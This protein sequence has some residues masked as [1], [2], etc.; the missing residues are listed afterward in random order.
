MA[1]LKSSME[2]QRD[3]REVEPSSSLGKAFRY[4]LGHWQ[5]LTQFLRVPGAPLDN[6]T[7]ERALKLIIRQRKNSL[8]YATAH[9]AYVASLLTS[10]IATCTQAGVNAMAYLV[11]LQEHRSAV[12]ANPADWLPW[13]FQATLASR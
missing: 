4:W 10:L 7:A 13:T 8:F 3:Q 6:N 1:T 12:F 5:T 11:A 2:T 9:S